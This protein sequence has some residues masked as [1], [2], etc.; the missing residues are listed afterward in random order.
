MNS[1]HLVFVS[2]AMN[3]TVL[4]ARWRTLDGS[5]KRLTA[6][7][8]FNMEN[9]R[10]YGCDDGLV[11]DILVTVSHKKQANSNRLGVAHSGFLLGL[12]NV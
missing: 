5:R 10:M 8:M 7:T 6:Q 2:F 4:Q 9:C 3:T 12:R 11:C 1:H